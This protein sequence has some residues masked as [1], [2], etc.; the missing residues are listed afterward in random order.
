MN[1][2]KS[3]EFKNFKF[4]N[5]KYKIHKLL[6]KLIDE[7]NQI[8]KSLSKSYKDSFKQS[9]L[10]KLKNYSNILII[11]MGGSILGAKAIYN[12][13]KSKIKKNFFFIDNLKNDNFD[14]IINKKK[15]N[16]IIS[17]SGNTLETIANSNIIINKRDKNIFITENKNNYLRSLA[18]ELK[19]D[20]INHNNYIGGRYSVLSEVGMVPA[21]LMG[22]N[23]N[24]FRVYNQLIKNKKFTNLLINNVSSILSLIKKKKTNSV[25]LN[26]DQISSDL[27]YWYQ[28]LVAESLGKKGKGILPIISNMPKDNHSLMQLYLDG[29]KNNFYTFFFV[30]E[31][32][33][34]KI[35]NS[36]II[37][38]HSYL[39]DKK[40]SDIRYS[41]CLATQS[42]FKKR[43]IPFR[44]FYVNERNEKT[45]G[46]LFSFFILE[47][48]LL[49]KA[50]N[51]NPYDQP[52][53]ELIKIHTKKSL[54]KL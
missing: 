54:I 34:K 3:I 45:L 14:E 26:Y 29:K 18:Q 12:F 51:V 20:I 22:L 16:L 7:N 6:K 42:V 10:L 27:F 32:F 9:E 2:T 1:L 50:L 37:N 13:C 11:G 49:G 24:K 5:S 25:I 17:K 31:K 40:L 8:L 35:I 38:S 19:S 4:K 30:K 44:S 47:T 21:K 43:N 41:Q 46:E 15:L 36:K 33:S 52:S 53:V 28:Q 23:V 39:K 48:I